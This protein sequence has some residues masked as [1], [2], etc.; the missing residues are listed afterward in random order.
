M[1]RICVIGAGIVGCATAYQ[2]ARA[3]HRVTLVDERSA[4]GMLTS[5]ANGAQLSYAYVEPFASPATLRALPKLLLSRASPVRFRLRADWR[6][7]AWGA[8]FLMACRKTQVQRA[9]RQLLE[10]ARSSRETLDDW[11]RTEA[12]QFSF[13]RNGKLVL[14]PDTATLRR[15]EAQV[16]LQA[17]FG[18]EQSVVGRSECLAIEPALSGS[19]APFVGGVWTPGECVADPRLLCGE[20]VR[21][22]RS[23]GGTTLFGER[24]EALRRKG[25]AIAAV[26][27]SASEVSADAFVLAAGPQ[28]ARLASTFGL[29]LPIYPIRG[30]SLTL[31]FRG[32]RRPKV[33]VTHLGQKT[34]Y[35]PVGGMLRVAGMAE[36]D[37]Y[38]NTVLQA[39]AT[40]LARSLE[41]LYPGVCNLEPNSPWSGLRPATPT[42]LPIIRAVPGTNLIINAGHGGLGL[43]L[44]AGS[45]K[46]V[47]Q[48][49]AGHISSEV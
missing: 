20:L 32:E 12:W 7:W 3:G 10:L 30:Y 49:V 28:A 23:L 44:A 46:L 33:S 36:I 24:V 31:G 16:R 35:A 34:V 21:S 37:G 26:R 15:Q 6:Q 9:T 13:A 45:A 48:L 5:A 14:C 22:L 47:E 18:S 11:M 29:H 38:E 25:S 40:T 19:A 27:T 39:R 8:R 41:E 42:S 43:T 1:S 17:S 4:P 2:L